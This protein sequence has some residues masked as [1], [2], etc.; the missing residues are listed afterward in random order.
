MIFLPWREYLPAPFT[1]G[2]VIANPG[3]YY[4]AGT[5][6]TG[7]N[8]GAGYGFAAQDPEHA[9]LDRMLGR[10]PRG[11]RQHPGEPAGARDDG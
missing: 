4:F 10:C 11:R 1:Q 7:Q 5:V 2:R 9:V 3:A 6:L 8:P